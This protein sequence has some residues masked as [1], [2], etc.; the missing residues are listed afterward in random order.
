MRFITDFAMLFCVTLFCIFW[1]LFCQ[2]HWLSVKII[3]FDHFTTLFFL[4]MYTVLKSFVKISINLEVCC[5]KN[6]NRFGNSLL[7]QYFCKKF[8]LFFR[9]L[10]TNWLRKEHYSELTCT[11][12]RTTVL[13][14][15]LKRIN[16]CANVIL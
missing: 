9:F 4:Y 16:V 11:T 1:P 13:S 8:V 10:N 3:F 6:A 12:W 2:L 5:F 14:Y 7:F 15:I